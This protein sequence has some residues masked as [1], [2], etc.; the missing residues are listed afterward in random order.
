MAWYRR[1]FRLNPADRGKN[2]EIQFDDVPID[3]LGI[4]LSLLFCYCGLGGDL[5]ATEL[6]RRGY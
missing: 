4:N 6:L 1:S 2:L 5:R 3:F